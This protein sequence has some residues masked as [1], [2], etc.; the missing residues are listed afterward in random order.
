M[1]IKEAFNKG[2]ENI[3]EKEPIT[4][5]DVLTDEEKQLIRE[6]RELMYTTWSKWKSEAYF[7]TIMEILEE[8]EERYYKE[9]NIQ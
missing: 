2:S 8:A 4:L 5:K 6:Y 1:L 9:R 3:M 7:K